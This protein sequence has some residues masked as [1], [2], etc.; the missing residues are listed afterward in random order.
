MSVWNVSFW[1][2]LTER[3]L[4]TAAQFALVTI[5]G[6]V[7]NAWD[8]DWKVIAGTVAAGALT[9]VLTSLA[10]TP[11]GNDG[12]ASVTKAVEAAPDT[13]PPG[14]HEAP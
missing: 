4:K 11:F 3:A 13:G 9:S 8:I 2:D 14:R 7:T 10:S 6:N 5:G 1:K 12:T